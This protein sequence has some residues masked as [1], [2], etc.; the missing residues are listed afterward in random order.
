MVGSKSIA[1]DL[2]EK[3]VEF[4]QEFLQPYLNG[5]EDYVQE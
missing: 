4:V 5:S 2:E 1:H 3:A